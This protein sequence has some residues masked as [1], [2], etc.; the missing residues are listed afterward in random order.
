MKCAM[1]DRRFLTDIF[2]DVD[3]AASWPAGGTD[4]VTQHPE[5][6]PDTLAVRDLNS[7]LEPS[8]G[9]TELIP[10]EQSCRCV[11]AS[12]TVSSLEGFLECLNYQES[13][14][15]IRVGSATRISF[16]FV[17]APTVTANVEGPLARIN[18]R[19]TG[20]I[21][22]VAPDQTPYSRITGVRCWTRRENRADNDR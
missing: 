10:G 12:Y 11:V 14:F 13:T 19:A 21:E 9:L 7:R 16:E 5:S 15:L 3:L 8:V 18:R 20:A 17:V 1:N 4:V 6:R 22:L 2:H